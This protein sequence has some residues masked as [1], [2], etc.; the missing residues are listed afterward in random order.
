MRNALADYKKK[1]KG[2]NFTHIEAWE[3][4][5]KSDKWLQQPTVSQTSSSN[6]E[7]RRKS[8]ESSN[9]NV[10]TIIPDLNDDTTPTRKKKGKK[11]ENESTKK[12]IESLADYAAKK[13][14]IMDENVEKKRA[15]EELTEKL[16]AAQLEGVQE[17]NF[18]RAMKFF[19]DPHDTILDPTMRDIMI[20]KKREVA[21]KYGWP[22]NF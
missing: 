4:V 10:E 15:K 13:S 22:C 11:A 6:T 14:Q 1:T 19:N 3:I 5:R 17:K 8:S 2:R 16:M 12:S 7:K 9:D 18:F 21:A 20:A